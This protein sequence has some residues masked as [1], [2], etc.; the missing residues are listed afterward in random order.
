MEGKR[1][2]KLNLNIIVF[3]GQQNARRNIG[4]S[5]DHLIRGIAGR[6]VFQTIFEFFYKKIAIYAE[7]GIYNKPMW[8][9][10]HVSDQLHSGAWTSKLGY[11][12][13]CQP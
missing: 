11:P 3:L 2:A 4:L 7:F 6:K 8:E 12:R 9:F 13:S 5:L 1:Q 10:T